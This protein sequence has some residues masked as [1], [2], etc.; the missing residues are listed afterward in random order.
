VREGGLR[1]G[2]RHLGDVQRLDLG[3]VEVEPLDGRAP[4]IAST[5]RALPALPVTKS[6]GGIIGLSALLDRHDRAGAL[7]G[8]R[9]I[10]AKPAEHRKAAFKAARRSVRIG[11]K[12]L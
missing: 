1:L 8:K 11:A 6:S 3:Q 7:K 9:G 5:S 4:R 12:V 2:P 10:L